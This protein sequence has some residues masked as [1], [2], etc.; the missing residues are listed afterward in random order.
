[1]MFVYPAVFHQEDNA[2]WVEFPDLPGCQSFGDT[3]PETMAEAQEALAA[4]V[5]TLLEQGKPLAQ[6]SDIGA[7]TPDEGFTSLVA[8]TIDQYKETKAVKKT[9]TIPSWLNDRATAMGVNFS[10]VLQEALI[11]K[12]QA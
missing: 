9:L 8:C 6:P 7:I 4:Y 12:I 1:M 5:L 2:Y 3:L 10:Q 11:T